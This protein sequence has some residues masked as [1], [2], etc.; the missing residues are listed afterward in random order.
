LPIQKINL[1]E[2]WGVLFKP[3]GATKCQLRR[4]FGSRR[5][6]RRWANQNNLNRLTTYFGVWPLG[7]LSI[8]DGEM[9]VKMK[10]H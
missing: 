4:G 7:D 3:H 1:Q 10:Y 6:A 5:V 2:E 8:R 9:F